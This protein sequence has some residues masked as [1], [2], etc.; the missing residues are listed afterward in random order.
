[1]PVAPHRSEGAEVT[2]AAAGTSSSPAGVQDLLRLCAA[3]NHAAFEALYNSCSTKVFGL[4]HQ[5]LRD[6]A[7]AEEVTQDIFVQIWIQAARF[8]ETRGSAIAWIMTLTHR[9]AVDRVRTSQARRNRDT[10]NY[11]TDFMRDFD[12]VPEQAEVNAETRLVRTCLTSLT[13][14]QRESIVLAYFDG[15]THAEISVLLALPVGTVKTRIRDGMIK[16]RSELTEA[17]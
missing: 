12:P 5:I 6:H 11:T 16:L 13:K 15:Y 9:R 10:A 2:T 4:T 3:G 7:Q 17:A 8:D 1:M 14:L